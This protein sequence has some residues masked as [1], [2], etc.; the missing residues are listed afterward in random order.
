MN[1]QDSLYD[2]PCNAID[3]DW[4]DGCDV[5]DEHKVTFGML[6]LLIQGL[7]Q[8]IK[9]SNSAANLHPVSQAALSD[10]WM[11]SGCNEKIGQN[12][13]D[14]VGLFQKYRV[15]GAKNLRQQ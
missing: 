11:L 4:C 13:N 5:G 6:I 15:G 8:T 10:R 2:P 7:N 3:T 14:G 12:Y 1:K 9:L